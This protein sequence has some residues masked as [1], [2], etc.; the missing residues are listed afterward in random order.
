MR[1]REYFEGIRSEVSSVARERSELEL[2]RERTGVRA[3]GFGPT[4]RHGGGSPSAM[5]VVDAAVD[6][7][8]ELAGRERELERSLGRATELLYGA[9]GRGGLAKLRGS[10]YA[11]AICMGYLQA[12]P[13]RE[14]AEV[15]MCSPRW[16][17]ELCD[18]AFRYIDR[19]GFAFVRDS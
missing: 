12:T 16:C 2:M 19:V 14:V 1:A 4:S 18:S 5:G 13:W 9:D 15:M 8:R 10:R 17:H 11:D 3:Q 6:R 7:E